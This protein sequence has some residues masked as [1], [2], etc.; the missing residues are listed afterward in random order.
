[1]RRIDNL[2]EGVINGDIQTPEH[3]TCMLQEKLISE[4]VFKEG[5]RECMSDILSNVYRIESNALILDYIRKEQMKYTEYTRRLLSMRD[6]RGRLFEKKNKLKT[7]NDLLQDLFLS[8]DRVSSFIESRYHMYID[9]KLPASYHN[10]LIEIPKIK[11]NIDFIL[12]KAEGQKINNRLWKIVMYIFSQANRI[13]FDDTVSINRVKYFK[14]ILGDWKILANDERFNED[15]ITENLIFMN[16]NY[17]K[18]FNYLSKRIEEELDEYE[19]IMDKIDRLHYYQHL[20]SKK[21][22][23]EGVKYT[24]ENKNIKNQMKIWLQEEIR[25]FASMIKDK[26]YEQIKFDYVNLEEKID[27]ELSVSQIAYFL[28]ILFDVGIVKNENKSKIVRIISQTVSSKSKKD[29]S[30]G[31]IQRKMYDADSYTIK[32]IRE[33]LLRMLSATRE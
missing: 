17:N 28:N 8:T 32:S 6:F 4:E 24:C 27:T 10:K 18:F 7:M 30:A 33:L 15:E 12:R 11:S 31:S 9:N 14:Q 5:I 26:A 13:A 29:I 22:I 3:I 1:M 16:F 25:Y 20:F 21:Y 23:L 19:N 2:M